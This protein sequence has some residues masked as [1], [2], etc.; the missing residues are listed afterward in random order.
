MKTC[1]RQCVCRWRRLEDKDGNCVRRDSEK[2]IQEANGG[3]TEPE[4]TTIPTTSTSTSTEV[5][6]AETTDIVLEASAEILVKE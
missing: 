6:D 4:E 5:L 3:E 1:E 2:C